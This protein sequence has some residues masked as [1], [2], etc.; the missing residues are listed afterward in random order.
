MDIEKT[1]WIQHSFKKEFK[2]SGTIN[3]LLHEF[4]VLKSRTAKHFTCHAILKDGTELYRHH[5]LTAKE[6]QK[7]MYCQ[8]PGVDD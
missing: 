6:G 1:K 4:R 7:T 5:V 8:Q 2:A 3:L